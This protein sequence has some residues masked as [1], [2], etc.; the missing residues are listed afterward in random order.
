MLYNKRRKKVQNALD[1]LS[2]EYF[3]KETKR[4]KGYGKNCFEYD[5]NTR[6]AF[7]PVT[8]LP[9]KLDKLD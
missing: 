2:C 1:C 5:P 3:D 6:T 4:F 9:I 8:K 7:D